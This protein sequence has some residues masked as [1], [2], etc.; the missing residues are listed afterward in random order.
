MQPACP[1]AQRTASQ[2]HRIVGVSYTV[3]TLVI[4]GALCAAM[5]G[6]VLLGMRV[7]ARRTAK[8]GPKPGKVVETSVFSVLALLLSF[9]FYGAIGR[10]DDHRKAIGREVSALDTAYHRLDLLPAP[11]RPELK[12][13]FRTYVDS[14]IDLYGTGVD[15]H[16]FAA[17]QS[18]ALREQIWRA[19]VEACRV[20]E[21]ASSSQTLVM[22]SLNDVFGYPLEQAVMRHMHPPRVVFG[23][24]F[25]LALLC[26]FLAGLDNPGFKL[27]SAI[28]VVLYPLTMSAIIWTVLDLEY[29]RTGVVRLGAFDEMLVS[30]RGSM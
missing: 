16:S 6:L 5:V 10:F 13:L 8:Y 20:P 22:T 7:A 17:F 29:P 30:L 3:L 9:S 1:I 27:R 2:L 11:S 18:A 14:R 4:V 25:S 19:A 24:L 21:C 15:P 28:I 23:L 26:A 12:R